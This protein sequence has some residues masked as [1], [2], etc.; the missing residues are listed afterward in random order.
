MH[1]M[2]TKPVTF[3]WDEDFLARV[4]QARG[5]TPRSAFVRNAIE[6]ALATHFAA[7][8]DHPREEAVSEIVER[9]RALGVAPNVFNI[10]A[11]MW[12]P[13]PVDPIDETDASEEA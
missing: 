7:V 1:H 13:K 6:V 2:Y 12:D 9:L 8:G 4:D 3:R 11:E 10:A 5:S